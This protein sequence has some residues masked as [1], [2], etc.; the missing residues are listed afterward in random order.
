MDT[1]ET[2]EGVQ[3][4]PVTETETQEQ[5]PVVVCGILGTVIKTGDTVYDQVVP[6]NGEQEE[7]IRIVLVS[8]LTAEERGKLTPEDVRIF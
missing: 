2:A 8:S 6:A 4:V 5:A 1:N 3:D 7:Y